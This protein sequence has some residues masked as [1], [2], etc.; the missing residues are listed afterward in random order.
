ME[1]SVRMWENVDQKKLRIRTLFTQRSF[2][3]LVLLFLTCNNDLSDNRQCNSK[4]FANDASLF[5]TV[6]IPNRK[7]NDLTN[8]PKEIN[9]WAFQWKMIFIPGPKKEVLEVI[10]SRKN[11]DNSSRNIFFNNISVS[12][13]EC[14]KLLG[15]DLD[16]KLFFDI[17]IITISTKVN[18]SISLLR[19]LERV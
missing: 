3:C 16:T 2:G 14:Q 17:H 7:A 8:D 1:Y 15:L 12:G 13:A 19:K 5:S 6:K 10:F 18:K 4:F 11:T 9:N